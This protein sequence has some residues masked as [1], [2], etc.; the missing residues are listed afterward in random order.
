MQFSRK[1]FVISTLVL[2]SAGLDGCASKIIGVRPGVERVSLADASQV[3]G[4]QS[5]GENTIS[6]LAKVV[7]LN[8][9]TEEVEANLYQVARNYAVDVGADTLVKGE[10][11]QFGE[12]T[13]YVYKCR[14]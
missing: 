8:R 11:K 6:V 13:F 10:S 2:L 4:C 7:G 5:K 3:A 1:V 14:P 12:R 9:S